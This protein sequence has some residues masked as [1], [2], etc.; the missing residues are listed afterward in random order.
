LTNAFLRCRTA[1]RQAPY[2]EAAA[3]MGNRAWGINK[4]VKFREA[5]R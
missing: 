5:V 1:G 4:R 2:R 3:R